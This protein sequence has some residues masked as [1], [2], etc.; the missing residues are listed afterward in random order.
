M[1]FITSYYYSTPVFGTGTLSVGIFLLSVTGFGVLVGTGVVVGVG[2]IVGVGVGPT[3]VGVGFGAGVGVGSGSVT[4]TV[5][6][7]IS[8]IPLCSVTVCILSKKP[9]IRLP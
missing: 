6:E 8:S 5:S 7:S 2:V 3:G 4:S 9:S 1:T